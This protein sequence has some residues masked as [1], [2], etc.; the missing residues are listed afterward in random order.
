MVVSVLLVVLVVSNAASVIIYLLSQTHW[1]DNHALRPLGFQK[2]TFLGHLVVSSGGILDWLGFTIGYR[3]STAEHLVSLSLTMVTMRWSWLLSVVMMS[4]HNNKSGELF[5]CLL[6][7][8]GGGEGK[9]R[10]NK[11]SPK[12]FFPGNFLYKVCAGALWSSVHKELRQGPLKLQYRPPLGFWNGSQILIFKGCG[13][14]QYIFHR[15]W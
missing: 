3:V 6:A 1:G 9:G 12:M 10:A 5:Y 15:Q 8:G 2:S 14:I 7:R 4:H 13:W 11:I